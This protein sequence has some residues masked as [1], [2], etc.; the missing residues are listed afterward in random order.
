MRNNMVQTKK[1]QLMNCSTLDE[2]LNV[3]YGEQ[4]TESRKQFDEET[5]AFCLAQT[6]KEERLRAGL[7]QEQLAEKIGTKKTYISRIEN[8]KSDV[9]LNTLFR[10]FEG[11]GRRV[12]L[13]I[14]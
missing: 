8:G 9:Q 10:I 1:N 3:E 14:L 13:T 11:L 5:Q 2:L 6:L 12:S 7:T 4:G